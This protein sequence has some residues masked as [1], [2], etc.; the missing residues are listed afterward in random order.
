MV[1]IN[2][3]SYSP[4]SSCIHCLTSFPSIQPKMFS[5]RPFYA[6]LIVCFFPVRFHPNSSMHL[7]APFPFSLPLVTRSFLP[8]WLQLS[9][10]IS[11]WFGERL[12]SNPQCCQSVPSAMKVQSSGC[13][14]RAVTSRKFSFFNIYLGGCYAECDGWRRA[15]GFTQ[16]IPPVSLEGALICGL[17]CWSMCS[18]LGDLLFFHTASPWEDLV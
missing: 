3:S 9:I 11:L 8:V 13:L 16:W 18:T 5:L 2:F 14:G 7:I 1:Y 10:N 6:L 12:A 15:A 4:T 17:N